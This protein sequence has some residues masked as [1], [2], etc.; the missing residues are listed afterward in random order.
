[1]TNRRVL[2]GA[3]LSVVALVIP[4]RPA[5]AA[6]TTVPA[7]C[8]LDVAA[9]QRVLGVTSPE[10]FAGP[11]VLAGEACSWRTT[12]PN[13]FLRSLS[14]RRHTTASERAAVKKL[15]A[16]TASYDRA[17]SALGTNA[18]FARTDLGPAAAID[19][20]RLYVPRGRDWIEIMLSGRLGADGSHD[21]LATAARAIPR[22]V[23]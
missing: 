17:P 6:A 20:E 18:F 5:T 7:V 1:M 14:L 22:S 19:I 3:V 23:V 13:C 2:V 12:D 9:V 8:R 10:K 15:L 11:D 4:S 21:L 16:T